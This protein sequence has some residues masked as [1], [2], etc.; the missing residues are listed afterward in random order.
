MDEVHPPFINKVSSCVL[1]V[2]NIWIFRLA[3]LSSVYA[4]LHRTAAHHLSPSVVGSRDNR[5]GFRRLRGWGGGDRCYPATSGAVWTSQR[6]VSSAPG[7]RTSHRHGYSFKPGHP[8][9]EWGTFSSL[10]KD[11]WN[12]TE[13]AAVCLFCLVASSGKQRVECGPATGWCCIQ[14]ATEPDEWR[15]HTGE[16]ESTRTW[17]TG[18][19]EEKKHFQET[20][21]NAR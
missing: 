4:V 6:R 15:F 17:E 16:H 20:Y 19:G 18:E 9:G 13:K 7:S 2:C 5:P 14:R 21:T 8:T 1:C 12:E 11:L 10:S 3:S